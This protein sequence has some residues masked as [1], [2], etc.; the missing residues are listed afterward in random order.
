MSPEGN[1]TVFCVESYKT[2][3]GMSGKQVVCLFEKY[4]VFDYLH[5]FYDILH[6]AGYQYIN[7]DI[8]EYLI[9]RDAFTQ[10]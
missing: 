1:F 6:T 4:N 7:R 9:N 8:D 10:I 3:K 2:Y 5:E